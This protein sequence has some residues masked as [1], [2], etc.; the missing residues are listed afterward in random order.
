MADLTFTQ[1]ERRNYLVP[2]LL[3]LAVLAVFFG[4]LYWRTPLRI[5]DGTVTHTNILPTH[6]V[7]KTG[8][9]LVG[10]TD[11]AEDFLYVLTTV[12]ID[13]HL[14]VPLFI[15][16][17]TG[18]F[19][20]QDDTGTE[21]SAIEKNDLANMFVT[22]PALKPL[23]SDPLLRESSIQPASHAEGMVLLALPITEADWNQRKSATVT[24]TFY[25][26]GTLTVTIPK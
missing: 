8:S 26:Q 7:F 19:T 23:A 21:T 15:N 9:T 10:A 1:P 16:D 11:Q 25:Q 20:A 17:I 3:A 6:T 22:F 12:R 4:Y 5:A 13:N 14:K 18:T 24:I 2:G